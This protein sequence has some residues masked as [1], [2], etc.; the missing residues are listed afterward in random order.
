MPER[1][2]FGR[3]VLDVRVTDTAGNVDDE[4]QRTR[5]RIVFNVER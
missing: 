4:L 1:V 2:G 5:N 3:Y